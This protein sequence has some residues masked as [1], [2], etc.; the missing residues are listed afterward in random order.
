M[1][2][3]PGF[4]SLLPFLIETARQGLTQE[5][6]DDAA[7]VD[8]P[9]ESAALV[10]CA[11]DQSIPENEE[12]A[13]A[14]EEAETQQTEEDGSKG[15][16]QE[17]GHE[18]EAKPAELETPRDEEPGPV[19]EGQREEEDEEVFQDAVAEPASSQETATRLGRSR[20]REKAVNGS[21]SGL[22]G[23]SNCVL[24]LG[25]VLCKNLT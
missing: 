16:G 4:D 24:L 14:A 18:T 8:N 9:K 11:T 20:G 2:Q 15:K 6:R 23:V 22:S 10:N 5:G 1:T 13:K 12:S 25:L 19:A 7:P 21:K 17:G 3:D